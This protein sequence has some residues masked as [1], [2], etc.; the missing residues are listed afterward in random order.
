MNSLIVDIN[1][2]TST[3]FK[4][5]IKLVSYKYIKSKYKIIIFLEDGIILWSIAFDHVYH[6]WSINLKVIEGIK[7]YL[8]NGSITTLEKCFEGSSDYRVN[9]RLKEVRKLKVR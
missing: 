8:L 9:N 1:I 5:K 2:L 7:D 3:S 4:V 6:G